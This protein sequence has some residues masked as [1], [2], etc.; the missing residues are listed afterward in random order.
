M[1]IRVDL[2]TPERHLF[3]EPAAESAL[4]PTV[5]GQ[6][7]VFTGHAALIALIGI[8]E[9]RVRKAEAEESIAVYGGVVHICRDQVILLADSA[10]FA[11]DLD[12]E[13]CHLARLAAEADFQS[14]PSPET[15]NALRRA[16]LRE[17]LARRVRQLGLPRLHTAPPPV[18]GRLPKIATFAPQPPF[19]PDL[20]DR[21]F[22]ERD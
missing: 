9:L 10:E 5:Q 18:D 2:V 3:H 22:A 21:L 19:V 13:A 6:I 1:P 20:P 12:L 14:A 17:R 16:M 15:R 7:G 4:V 11:H 8:G